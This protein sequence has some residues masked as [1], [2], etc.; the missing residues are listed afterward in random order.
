MDEGAVFTI[1]SLWTDDSEDTTSRLRGMHSTISKDHSDEV[2]DSTSGVPAQLDEHD[3]TAAGQEWIEEQQTIDAPSDDETEELYPALTSTNTLFDATKLGVEIRRR[4]EGLPGIGPSD[5]DPNQQVVEYLIKSVARLSVENEMLK[6]AALDAQKRTAE[7]RSASTPNDNIQNSDDSNTP[8]F[9]EYHGVRCAGPKTNIFQDAPRVFK[10]DRKSDHLRGRRGIA[11]LTAHFDKSSQ[12]AY[13][14]VHQYSCS[15][16]GGP[17]YHHVVG[18]HDGKLLDDSAPAE[19]KY[20]CLVLNKSL[21]ETLSR[22]AQQHQSRFQ[23]LVGNP[24]MFCYEPF[25]PFYLHNK[26]FLELAA[27][28]NLSDFDLKATI[29]LCTWF[30]DNFRKVWD[31]TDELLSRGKITYEHYKRLFR[32]GELVVAV[33]KDKFG[34]LNAGR[35]KP[36]SWEENS[37]EVYCEYWTFNGVFQKVEVSWH[38]N[39]MFKS[40]G[41]EVAKYDGEVDITDLQTYP[42][43]FADPS[44]RDRLIARGNRFWRCRKKTL[45]SYSDPEHESDD[46]V[47]PVGWC[48]AANSISS[49]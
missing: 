18:S 47:T 14:I 33:T 13:A 19:T 26:T 42:L 37:G 44:A 4:L 7:S 45:V 24:R 20:K 28:S 25:L 39:A 15:C 1:P 29:S 38:L 40:D 31:E 5:N 22:I 3:A 48:G 35:V 6:T 43:R 12:L 10:G 36:H 17:D 23:G 41:E 8:I 30:E 32:P 46:C 34:T 11:D 2:D 9:K 49:C 27:S 16:Y 21:R